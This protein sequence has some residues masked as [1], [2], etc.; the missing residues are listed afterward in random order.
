MKILDK[1]AEVQR[2][3][4]RKFSRIGKGKYSRILKMAR[5]PTRDEYS[6]VVTITGLGIILVG[7]VGFA[8]YMILQVYLKIPK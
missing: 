3:I 1:S 2:N 6:K 8:I 5:K 7:G 4:E